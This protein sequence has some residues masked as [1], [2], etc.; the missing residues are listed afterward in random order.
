MEGV[1]PYVLWFYRIN[2]RI[3]TINAK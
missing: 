3:M 2:W 1:S